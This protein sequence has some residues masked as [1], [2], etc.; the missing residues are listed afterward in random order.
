MLQAL[1]LTVKQHEAGDFPVNFAN[2]GNMGGCDFIDI[3]SIP[4]AQRLVMLE[5]SFNLE[6]HREMDIPYA[7]TEYNTSEGVQSL[8]SNEHDTE[9]TDA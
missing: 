2:C 1:D 3:C 8:S 6:P 5:E 9:T 4:P 7:L